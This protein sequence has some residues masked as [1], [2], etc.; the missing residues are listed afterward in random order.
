MSPTKASLARFHPNILPRAKSVE[1]LRPVSKEIHDTFEQDPVVGGGT[2]QVVGHAAGT[3]SKESQSG[4]DGMEKRHG[5]L[6]TPAQR[7]PSPGEGNVSAK[8]GQSVVDPNPRASPPEEARVEGTAANCTNGVQ[9]EPVARMADVGSTGITFVPDSQNSQFPSTPTQRGPYVPTSGMGI[10]EDGEPSLPSTP[11]QLGLEPPRERPKGLLFSSPSRRSK[12]RGRSSAKSSPLKPPNVPPEQPTQTQKSSTANLGPRRYIA[13]TPKPPLSLEEARLV[14]MQSKLSEVEKQLQ[15]IEDKVLRQLLV[16]S[17]QPGKSKEGKYMAKQKEEVTR[18]STKIFQLRDEILQIQATQGIDH[19]QTRPEGIDRK[20]AST[21]PSSLTQRLARY[22]PFSTK[23]RPPEPRP[24]SP[25]GTDVDQVLDL[26]ILQP[27]VVPFTIT[28]SNKLLLPPTV[29]N[30]LLQ[31]QDITMS[32]AQQLLICDLQLTANITTQQISHLDIQA[33]SSWAEPELGSWL[34][35]P[36]EKMELAAL[37]RAFGRYWEVAKLRG[38]CWIS[39]KQD[40]RDLVTNA[41]ESNSPL[42]FLGVQDLIFARSNVQLKVTWRISLSDQGEVESHSSA[43]PRFP[44]A[45]QQEANSELTKIGDAFIM[46]VEDRGIPEAIGMIC[47]VVF[48][49]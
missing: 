30:D 44:A 49:T 2:K 34:R 45:W 12:R 18:R 19:S 21:K 9:H 8:Q 26:D 41:P 13:N 15:N 38:K 14:E 29:D 4:M 33:L 3:A 22:L 43:Y 32:M 39:C 6:V 28:T 23:S 20:A 10:G 47:K 7:S 24:P 40:F 37:G 36:C 27:T 46:L 35:Q 11:S 16:S 31:R 17:W 42:F 48:P 25:K 5:L 1:P